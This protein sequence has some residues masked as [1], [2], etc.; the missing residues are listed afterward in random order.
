MKPLRVFLLYFADAPPG[1]QVVQTLRS[2]YLFSSPE[3]ALSRRVS[4]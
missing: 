1:V 3:I 2:W 4:K